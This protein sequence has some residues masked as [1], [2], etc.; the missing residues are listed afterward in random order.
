ML[1]GMVKLGII[2]NLMMMKYIRLVLKTNTIL[3]LILH[4]EIKKN[5]RFFW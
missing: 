3:N 5:A 4:M 1:W 2:E